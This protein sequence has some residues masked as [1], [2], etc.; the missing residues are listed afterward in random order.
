MK[1]IA[2]YFSLDG[3]AHDTAKKIAGLIG[4]DLLRL[5]PVKAYPKGKSKYFFGGMGAVFG[6]KPKLVPYRFCAD[7][8]DLLIIGTP[9]WAGN[10]TPPIKT[11]LRE[12]NLSNKKVALYT[13]SLGGG[14]DK[15][16]TKLKKE[17]KDC[18][19]ITT[20]E[21]IEPLGN[22]QKENDRKIV[23]FCRTIKQ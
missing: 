18:T 2:V 23:E 21:L 1:A 7:D 11:F 8:Y 17:L 10:F 22:P 20:L 15:C 16:F 12:Q 14:S 19:V 6:A 5:E 3:N 13:C 4:A 9:I